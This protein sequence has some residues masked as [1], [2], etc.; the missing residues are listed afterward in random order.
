MIQAVAYLRTSSATNVGSEKDSESRQR[1]A[2]ETY[3][4]RAGLEIVASF[5]DAAVSGSDALEAR[6]GFSALLD[7]IERNGVRTVIIEDA[8]RLARDLL[9]QELGIISLQQRAVTVLT[10][11]GDDL[12][13]TKDPMKVAMRQI[14]GAFSQLEK[15][16]LVD[17]LTKGRAKKRRQ[18]GYCEGAR[19]HERFNL[20][21]CERAR[22]LASG[23]KR[24]SLRAI[25][26]QL[27]LENHL[28]RTYRPFTAKVVATMIK[29]T[30][31]Q[32]DK[33]TPAFAA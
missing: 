11:S 13:D 30:V 17:K 1:E 5:Y 24:P 3:A 12:T 29:Q 2:I 18:H 8:S 15:T 7:K 22:Q 4:A 32:Q 10:A 6:P 19:P 27:A 33:V 14:A 21:A 26:A 25:A 23:E 9:T 28:S 31:L 20:A 16:R